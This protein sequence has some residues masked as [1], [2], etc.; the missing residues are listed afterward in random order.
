MEW[1]LLFDTWLKGKRHFLESSTAGP[2]NEMDRLDMRWKRWIWVP[3][4][5]INRHDLHSFCTFKLQVCLEKI[6]SSSNASS[7]SAAGS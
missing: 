4:D 5:D 7:T 1:L 3:T 6:R 2:E